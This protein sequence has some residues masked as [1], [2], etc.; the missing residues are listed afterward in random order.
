[1]NL[2]AKILQKLL[3]REEAFYAILSD[4]A[5]L[6]AES[7]DA[8]QRFVISGTQGAFEGKAA[9]EI[10]ESRSRAKA[11][12][13]DFSQQL[14]RS[15]ITPFDR[16]DMLEFALTLQ[17]NIKLIDKIKNR[18]ERSNAVDY[19]ADFSRMLAIMQKQVAI[20]QDVVTHL[21]SNAMDETQSAAARLN[22]LEREAD[23]L[24]EQLITDLCQGQISMQEA[25]VRKDI[26]EMFERLS[27][28]YR[29]AGIVA[30]QIVLKHN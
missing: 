18:M 2:L 7:L 24:L 28:A 10:S 25:F 4:L 1:M 6:S 15:F 23:E 19:N 22:D 27:D 11:I 21:N 17:R 8:L 14:G 26:Y 29:D 13:R 20:L 5:E 12:C 9:Q 16:E 3:P 30:E